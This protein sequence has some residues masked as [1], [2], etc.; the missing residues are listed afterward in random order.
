MLGRGRSR[1]RRAAI[2]LA[3]VLSS[4]GALNG[5]KL[6]MGQVPMA[7]ALDSADQLTPGAGRP[8]RPELAT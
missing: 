4:I 3:V 1:C 7:A 8:G 6:L 5:W 2:S